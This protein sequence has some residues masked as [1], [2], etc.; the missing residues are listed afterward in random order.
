M[1]S[2]VMSTYLDQNYRLLSQTS[3]PSAKLFYLGLAPERENTGEKDV[4]KRGEFKN[5]TSFV[6]T[7]VWPSTIATAS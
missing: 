6:T 3:S 7:F 1:L 2:A 4:E 5:K